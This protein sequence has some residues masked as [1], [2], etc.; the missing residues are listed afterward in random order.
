MIKARTKTSKTR[1][2]SSLSHSLLKCFS[3]P[4]EKIQQQHPRSN[5]PA[6]LTG[7][8]EPETRWCCVP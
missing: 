3:P 6:G 7:E 1:A 5:Q 4:L 8:V 2:G